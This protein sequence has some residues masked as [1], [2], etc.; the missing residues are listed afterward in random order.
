MIVHNFDPVLI[1]LGY[2]QIRWYSISYILGIILGWIYAIKIIKQVLKNNHGYH[3]VRTSDFDDCIIYI[4]IGIVIGAKGIT[5]IRPRLKS[6]SNSF[7][8]LF[9]FS[10]SSSVASSFI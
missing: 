1:D 5:V 2:L 4:V 8:W 9:A 3:P 7:N 10:K 6:L